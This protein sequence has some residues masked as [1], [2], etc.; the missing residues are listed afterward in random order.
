MTPLGRPVDPDVKRMYARLLGSTSS[1]GLAVFMADPSQKPSS[2][3]T[4]SVPASQW[5]AE[6]QPCHHFGVKLIQRKG[7]NRAGG[8]AIVTNTSSYIHLGCSL[9][10]VS[11]CFLG[12]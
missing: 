12:R 3:R 10:L 5:L 11:M 7:Q 4:C 9:W 8:V 6:A 2:S 1:P